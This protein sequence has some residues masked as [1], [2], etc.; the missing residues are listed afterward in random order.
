MFFASVAT[1]ACIGGLI[2]TKI[3]DTATPE[4]ELGLLAWGLVGV[5][6]GA[7]I[8]SLLGIG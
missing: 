4:G 2:G 3:V 8:A 6:V 1:G 7:V 5:I